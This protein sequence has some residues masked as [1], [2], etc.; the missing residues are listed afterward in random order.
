MSIPPD[1]IDSFNA[2]DSAEGKYYADLLDFQKSASSADRALRA[3]QI[4]G[5]LANARAAIE[6]DRKRIEIE[7]GRAEA[8]KWASEQ[9]VK[10]GVLGHMIQ[11]GTLGLEYLKTATEYASTPDNYFK[12]ADFMRGAS[13]RQDVPIFMQSLLEGVQMP[14]WTTQGG[15]PV[16]RD[17]NDLVSSFGVDPSQIAVGGEGAPGASQGTGLTFFGGRKGNKVGYY[18]QPGA[19]GQM[20]QQGG[21]MQQGQQGQAAPMG[22][23]VAGQRMEDRAPKG[24]YYQGEYD[25]SRPVNYA[26]PNEKGRVQDRRMVYTAPGQAAPDPRTQ[27][28]TG[29]VKAM[30]PSAGAGTDAQDQSALNAIS[31]LYA[32]P[33]NI[34][35]GA[36]EGLSGTEK[37]LTL[38]GM[39]KVGGDPKSWLTQWQKSRPGQGSSTSA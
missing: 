32:A 7:R 16:P 34:Q 36:W 38:A 24:S 15:V 19:Q 29:I 25:P 9:Q 4:E 2:R 6:N 1:L 5:S 21:V 12:L 14:A 35:P 39:A 17:I 27:A 8:D 37:S 26:A 3:K 28:V 31:A 22:G 18:D 23:M 33:Q 30:T 13:Q 11:R 20:A 10:L